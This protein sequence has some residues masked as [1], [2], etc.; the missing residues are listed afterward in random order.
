MDSIALLPLE[1][2]IRLG[3]FW[4]EE[5]LGE[6]S[7]GRVYL[8]RHA[9]LGSR[10]AVK[11]LN[12]QWA[13]DPSQWL[14]LL[15]EGR[16]LAQIQ[17]PNLVRAYDLVEPSAEVG[18]Y[19]VMEFL[20]GE[21]LHKRLVRTCALDVDDA[22]RF[23]RETAAALHALHARDIIHRDVKPANIFLVHHEDGTVHAKVLDLGIAKPIGELCP[24]M[25]QPGTLIGTPSYMAP[26]QLFAGPCDARVDVYALGLVLYEMLVRRRPNEGNTV[27]SI[28]RLHISR[29][30]L[31][32]PACLP[33]RLV[34]LIQ[35][36]LEVDP[37]RRPASMAIA[38]RQLAA[39]E[40]KP[41]VPAGRV[42]R[43]G[44]T[45]GRPRSHARARRA[46]APRPDARGRGL[47]PTAIPAD[48]TSDPEATWRP[49]RPLRRGRT[50]VAMGLLL[51]CMGDS[52]PSGS[53]DGEPPGP[54]SA[55][56]ERRLGWAT[57]PTSAPTAASALRPRRSLTTSRPLDRT[58]STLTGPSHPRR[59]R[60]FESTTPVATV[61]PSIETVATAIRRRSARTTTVRRR[62]AGE[63]DD[64][65]G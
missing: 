4:L 20:E 38:D 47:H 46:A 58:D 34:R 63:V 10:C 33:E 36:C 8:A 55:Q 21:S 9:I 2:R 50:I 11:I 3:P 26:E 61:A 41:L 56:R 60:R 12:P 25:T 62:C 37:D 15:R 13:A 59:P 43:S 39:E 65:S 57:R 40:R 30:R 49:I 27:A 23:A 31:A 32:F 24:C 1:R 29:A 48:A 64:G 28:Q 44:R 51:A 7:V 22:I 42:L 17:H 19:L 35:Q 52:R 14:R 6:G 45:D 16:I 54:A 18:G 5:L 53:T